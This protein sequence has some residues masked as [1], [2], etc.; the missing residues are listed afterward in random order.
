[1]R[2]NIELKA[3]LESIQNSREIAAKLTDQRK[4]TL[5][6]VDTYFAV[7]NGRLKI[8]VINHSQAELI[9][10]SRAD[11]TTSKASHYDVVPL[12]HWEAVQKTLARANGILCRVI[13]HRELYMYRNVRIHL[14]D[15]EQLGQFLEFEAVLSDDDE[16]AE[17]EGHRLVEFLRREFRIQNQDLVA[18]SYSDLIQTAPSQ[19]MATD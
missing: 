10:Y 6:Q 13:K 9:G 19:A 11:L 14:D 3:R 7:A 15:V 12:D 4:Q 16:K 1:M 5:H 18:G 17:A 2:K 8:R